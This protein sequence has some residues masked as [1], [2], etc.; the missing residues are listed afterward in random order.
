MVEDNGSGECSLTQM[1][2]TH[3]PPVAGSPQ[4][5]ENVRIE[6]V[7]SAAERT[8]GIS[9]RRLVII[10]I[11]LCLTIFL[12]A[13]DQVYSLKSHVDRDYCLNSSSNNRDWSRRLFRI[14]MDRNLISPLYVATYIS[15]LMAALFHYRCTGKH[16][17]F[18]VE[19]RFCL[20]QSDSSN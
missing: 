13:L 20:Y 5:A 9:D 11:G 1:E 3:L 4:V 18:G 17:I 19:S 10:V 2:S 8:S 15:S 6:R 14:Y 12:T 16:Q 7:G